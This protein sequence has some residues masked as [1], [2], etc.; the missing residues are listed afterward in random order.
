[1]WFVGDK[2]VRDTINTHFLSR[3][4]DNLHVPSNFAVSC[5][6]DGDTPNVMANIVNNTVKA[7]NSYQK[8]PKWIVV[9]IEDDMLREI[10]LNYTSYKM[11]ESLGK[12]IDWVMKEQVSAINYFRKWLPQKSKKFQWPFILWITPTMHKC[13][14]PDLM[15]VRRKF[16][17][18]L[19]ITAT[20]HNMIVLPLRQVWDEDDL[21]LY[22]IRNESLSSVGNSILWTAID[23]TIRYADVKIN[24]NYG[25]PVNAIFNNTERRDR[26]G[27]NRRQDNIFQLIRNQ[28]NAPEF[29]RQTNNQPRRRLTFD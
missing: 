13:Y 20:R 1:M 12:M 23:C 5:F 3:V 18:S 21:S 25:R 17:T 29:E 16:A 28:L 9:V 8:L 26:N 10:N 15:E 2:F 11:S 4:R 14:P 22:N 6:T 27:Q 24:R 7:I 19:K